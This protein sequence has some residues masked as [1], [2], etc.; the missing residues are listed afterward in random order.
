[1]NSLLKKIC[2]LG[3]AAALAFAALFF[4][5]RN[6]QSKYKNT[7]S[8]EKQT[9][10]V[11]YDVNSKTNL[12]GESPAPST[13]I[14]DAA[15]ADELIA[16]MSIT[17]SPGEEAFIR[18]QI[19]QV[20]AQPLKISADN[21]ESG[22]AQALFRKSFCSNYIGSISSEQKKLLTLPENDPHQLTYGIAAELFDAMN[23]APL[24]SEEIAFLTKQLNDVIA[25]KESGMEILTAA[26]ALYQTGSISSRTLDYAK[27]NQWQLSPYE[28]AQTQLLSI[29][30]S[31][32]KKFGG[33]GANKLLTIKICGEQSACATGA[34]ADSIWRRSNSPAVYEAARQ[35][36]NYSEQ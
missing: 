17:S 18:I 25:S 30:M 14:L 15:S 7:V 23:H 32:C 34:T 31:A 9:G 36:S 27:L 19:A 22:R 26:E 5:A 4:L 3:L 10:F 33:C 12:G 24:N 20:C 6:H 11:S 13:K 35:L 21:S 16:E 29:Q 28:L 1:V 8:I 2:A